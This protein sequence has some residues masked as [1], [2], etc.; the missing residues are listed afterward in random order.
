MC[1]PPTSVRAELAPPPCAALAQ[2]A[3]AKVEAALKAAQNKLTA[4]AR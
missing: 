2:D 1:V 4:L 3:V